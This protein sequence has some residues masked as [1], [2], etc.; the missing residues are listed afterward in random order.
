MIPAAERL[1][2][3]PFPSLF[4]LRQRGGKAAA[5][6]LV[7]AASLLATGSA[8][9][10]APP[11]RLLITRANYPFTPLPDGGAYDCGTADL[12][13]SASYLFRFNNADFD[14]D[15]D[16]PGRAPLLLTSSTLSGA[17]TNN[18]TL[19]PVFNDSTAPILY[20]RSFT[21]RLT[22]TPGSTGV[23]STTLTVLS[24]DPEHSAYTVTLH[25]TGVL[26]SEIGIFAG[27]T[28]D[29]ATALATDEGSQ[30][31]PETAPGGSSTKTFT[32]ANTGLGDLALGG[33]AFVGTN[34]GDF[35]VT[36]PPG[37]STIPPGQSTTFTVTF[38][39]HAEG[40]RRAILL[41]ASNDRNEPSFH[42]PLTGPVTATGPQIEVTTDQS[43]TPLVSGAAVSWGEN[44]KHV[45][46]VPAGLGPLIA[47]S[48]GN[49]FTLALK[50]DGTVAA[51][52]DNSS[53]Q[54]DIP[55][56]LSGV[57]AISAGGKHSL[58]LKS[59]GT[60]VAWGSSEEEQ[61]VVPAGLTDVIAISAGQLTSL[62]LK[63]DGSVVSWGNQSASTVP[64]S[65]TGIT[66]IASGANQSLALRSDGTVA[67][68]SS[69]PITD[70]R[71]QP[72]A[73]LS[74]V[75][76]IAT[77][78]D[79]C[80]ALKSDGSVV[81]WA[82]DPFDPIPAFPAGPS[83]LVAIAAGAGDA[84]A[85]LHRDGT[86]L[87]PVVEQPSSEPPSPLIPP[88]GLREVTAVTAGA[89][90]LAVL[91]TSV[92]DFGGLNLAL[93]DKYQFVTVRNTGAAPLLLGEVT[94]TGPD[95]A[96]FTMEKDG[97]L[98]TLDPGAVTGLVVHFHP[99]AEGER[100]ATLHFPSN[101]AANPDLAFPLKGAAFTVH[102]TFETWKL[103][104]FATTAS[105]GPA[106]DDA[107][108]N[109]NGIPNLLEFALGG[110][111]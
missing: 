12:T 11:P 1:R 73:G 85:G 48:A 89:D 75:V 15:Y 19:E 28:Q 34:A 16:G 57:T 66:A 70:P 17:D 102:G 21:Y 55:A 104:Y 33:I 30:I 74:D 62:A 59:D 52:G 45:T 49:R 37:I 100:H 103:K 56:G 46:E 32:I 92:I 51:W 27:L 10:D 86:L 18:F 111:P 35:S 94:I 8:L 26:G 53:G 61:T 4:P 95:A 91:R 24:N 14:H 76:A 43:A 78:F 69:N 64:A 67:A 84:V 79:G 9:A 107:D 68:W 54:L 22:F 20:N 29:P 96:F 63:S 60:V 98:T 47:I 93:A 6:L 5:L 40:S 25:P 110:D 101:A 106:A 42:I 31:F 77:N 36:Q 82:Y 7:A 58:A 41:L 39:P 80:L 38:S 50:N 99:T 83:D 71:Y 72:P 88:A 97:I 44:T 109:L 65:L 90:H 81:A 87:V 23:K 105:T 108:P 2:P 13:T 3:S